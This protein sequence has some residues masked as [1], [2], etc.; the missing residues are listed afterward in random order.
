M[1]G[2]LT[3]A[4]EKPFR[5]LEP[6]YVGLP[7]GILVILWM[8]ITYRWLPDNSDTFLRDGRD[9]SQDMVSAFELSPGSKYVGTK[10]NA[11]LSAAGLQRRDLLKIRRRS[12]VQQPT[13]AKRASRSAAWRAVF[14]EFLTGA[15]VPDRYTLLSSD[16]ASSFDRC[17]VGSQQ[18][19]EIAD[20]SA[21]EIA[22]AGDTYLVS[23]RQET[24]FDVV[25]FAK[26]HWLVSSVPAVKRIC[27]KCEFLRV[28]IGVHSP[29]VHTTVHGGSELAR[30]ST[31]RV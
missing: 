30:N 22:Q 7:L 16:A 2:L 5:F 29:L 27:T 4:I 13:M 24:I 28:V 11:V 15:E 20:P 25:S 10:V 31:V 1:N 21:E 12:E 17:Y 18:I 23:V 19:T 14:R 8:V 3:A 9:R 6:A 26:Q